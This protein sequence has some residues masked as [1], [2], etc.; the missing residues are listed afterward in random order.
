MR[1][2]VQRGFTLVEMTIV[3]IV[4]GLLIA[5]VL[6]GQELYQNQQ[7][8]SIQN[9]TVEIDAAFGLFKKAYGELPGDISNPAVVPNCNAAPCNF[10]GNGV[11]WINE[12]ANL[13]DPV[14]TLNDERTSAWAQL[15]AAGLIGGMEGGTDLEPGKAFPVNARKGP[16]L[17]GVINNNAVFAMTGS[18]VIS[19]TASVILPNWHELLH[20]AEVRQID[21]K[22]DDGV[23]TTGQ[24][25]SGFECRTGLNG[26]Y[27]QPTGRLCNYFYQLTTQY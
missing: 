5:A 17:V 20:P 6:G 16:W 19:P 22:I 21:Q 23:A 15:H 7:V 9:Q 1:S 4:V 14:P 12:A 25:Q 11:G 24:L 10:A 27:D 13:W 26:D 8:R 2:F 3:M 18:N